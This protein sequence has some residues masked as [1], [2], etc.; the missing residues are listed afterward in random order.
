MSYD[1]N[2]CSQSKKPFGRP[3]MPDGKAK[4]ITLSLK[5][6]QEE[7]DIWTNMAEAK[8]MKLREYIL[9]PHRQALKRKGMA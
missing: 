3:P 7:I 9:H 6:S 4:V 5:V 8:G 1:A 2:N